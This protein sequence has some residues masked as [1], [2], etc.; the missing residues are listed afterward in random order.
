MQLLSDLERMAEMPW[1]AICAA[2]V[3]LVAGAAAHA[4]VLLVRR[5]CRG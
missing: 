2:A 5:L 4:G 1:L 3:F